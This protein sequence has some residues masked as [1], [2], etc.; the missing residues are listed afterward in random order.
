[1]SE[2]GVCRFAVT[3]G[4]FI[5]KCFCSY[6]IDC[7]SEITVRNSSIS[8]FDTPQWLTKKKKELFNSET[9]TLVTLMHQQ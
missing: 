5:R 2:I 1:M 8:C 6:S 7:D 3:T 9:E 4:E